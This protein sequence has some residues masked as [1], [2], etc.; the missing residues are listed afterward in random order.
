VLVVA[1]S[2]PKN[3]SPWIIRTEPREHPRLRLFCFP[4]AGGGSHVYRGWTHQ[5]RREIECCAVELPGRGSR[6]GEAPFSAM[7]PLVDALVPAL[8]P[9]LDLPFAFFGHSMGAL[10]AFELT[11]RLRDRARP[12]PVHLFVSA[13]RPPHRR[14]RLEPMHGLPRAQLIARLA[15]LGG[16]PP[17]LLAHGE[18]LDTIL[19][20]LRA[21]LAVVETYAVA[22]GSPLPMPLTAWAGSHDEHVS[23]ADLAGWRRLTTACFRASLFPGN[24]FFLRERAGSLC[25]SIGDLVSDLL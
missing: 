24:H 13:C 11:R 2:V 19:P 8:E 18:L 6:L 16:T 22:Q 10:V 5:L 12:L 17:E 25:R 14:A 15:A 9:W 23:T 20:V 3:F 21:D 1:L 7:A 4:Y